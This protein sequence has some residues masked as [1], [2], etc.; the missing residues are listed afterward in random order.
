MRYA[1]LFLL[2][3]LLGCATTDRPTAEMPSTTGS[4]ARTRAFDVPAL[5]G[6]NANQIDQ[7]LTSTA[8]QPTHQRTLREPLTGGSEA[9]TTYWHDTTAL[10][11]SYEPTSMR[12]TSFFV[13]TKHGLTP[14]YTSLL[15]LAG[16][17]QYDKRLNVEP[18]ASVNNPQL[19]TGVK[20]TPRQ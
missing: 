2:I 5:L 14:D 12:V 10:V 6:L 1:C 7:P 16:V 9:R 15:R 13:K 4:L 18:I 19:Y 8:I 11:V 17:S 3:F 20:L